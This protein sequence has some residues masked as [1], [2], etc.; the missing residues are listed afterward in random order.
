MKANV[1]PSA[2]SALRLPAAAPMVAKNGSIRYEP[3]RL[4]PAKGEALCDADGDLSWGATADAAAAI[5][6]AATAMHARSPPAK[7]RAP[8]AARPA[9]QAAPPAGTAAMTVLLQRRGRTAIGAAPSVP[10]TAAATAVTSASPATCSATLPLPLMLPL[11]WYPLPLPTAS[12]PRPLWPDCCSC[13]LLLTLLSVLPAAVLPESLS[14]FSLLLM[15]VLVLVTVSVPPLRGTRPSLS[16]ALATGL[17]RLGLV[18]LSPKR[19]STPRT[20]QEEMTAR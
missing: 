11:L 18:A 6:V 4:L 8:A 9:R 3:R 16:K 14:T 7:P 20:G 12:N 17:L 1:H 13:S 19:A 5:A 2:G 15:I 10:T